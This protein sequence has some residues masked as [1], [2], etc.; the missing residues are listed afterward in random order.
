MFPVITISILVSK[1]CLLLIAKL[2][3]NRIARDAGNGGLGVLNDLSVL[4]ILAANISERAARTDKLSDNGEFAGGIN[5]LSLAVEILDA[6]AVG[7]V[8]AAVRIAGSGVASARI[9]TT[10]GVA[11]ADIEAIVVA[12]MRSESIR[13][14]VGFPDVHFGATGSA[15]ADSGI[16]VAVRG[17]P[18]LRIGLEFVRHGIDSINMLERVLTIPSINLRSRGH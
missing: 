6:H 3:R 5:S 16:L 17:L 2:L 14:R 1:Y 9:G 11:G 12:G 7:I 18:S 8:V 4:D 13:D 15:V 10:A